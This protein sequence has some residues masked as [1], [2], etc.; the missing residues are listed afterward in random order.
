MRHAGPE[1]DAV[2]ALSHTFLTWAGTG[3]NTQWCV[4]GLPPSLGSS[5][6]SLHCHCLLGGLLCKPLTRETSSVLPSA[7]SAVPGTDLPG[8]T[9]LLLSGGELN[10]VSLGFWVAAAFLTLLGS[11]TSGFDSL[12]IPQQPPDSG[13]VLNA[14]GRVVGGGR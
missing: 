12:P 4:Q 14:A 13:Q 2:M 6:T 9:A 3:H 8:H 7:L 10:L 11:R 1:L 5:P